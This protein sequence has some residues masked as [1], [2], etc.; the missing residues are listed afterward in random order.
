MLLIT[1]ITG[2]SGTY[3]LNELI[4]N[5]IT[6]CEKFERIR[7][8]A[9][10]GSNI[11]LIDNCKLNIE[12]CIGNLEEED[13][14]KQVLE[15]VDI[16]FHIAGINLSSKIVRI[17]VESNIK[18]IILVHT[19]GIYSKYKAAGE[20]YRDIEKEIY[21]LTKA[22]K[23]DLTILRP[24]MIY[25]SVNDKNIIVF[26]KMIDKFKIMPIVNH[27]KYEL[28][29]VHAKD[30]GKAYYQVLMNLEITQ[31]KNYNLS[32]KNPIML[33]D[34]FREIEKNIGQKKFYV[35]IPFPIA[36]MGAW[37]IYFIT[38]T[39]KDFREKVQRL[40]ES[41][42][43][44]H[45]EAKKDFEYDPIPFEEGIIDEIENYLKLNNS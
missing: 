6:V 18:R 17:A 29:P 1:G 14:L 3:F 35:N 38:F 5:S 44:L 43:F 16:L 4:N 13:F 28:Q 41:R 31:N 37:F 45:E 42:V 24:T 39:K 21:Q 27:A 15:N 8:T 22:N 10:S 19:T 32:G 34:I 12:K 30:L 9:R 33:I 23:I 25:G 2:H 40:C 7:I 36:Y 11:N 20:R 26:I